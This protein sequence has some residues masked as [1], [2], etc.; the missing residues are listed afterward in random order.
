MTKDYL[1][2]LLFALGVA[3]SNCALANCESKDPSNLALEL[4]RSHYL[5]LSE[6]APASI[7]SRELSGLVSRELICRDQGQVCAIDW[8]FWTGAQDGQVVSGAKAKMLSTTSSTAKIELQYAFK[9][10]K[11]SKAQQLR[12]ELAFIRDVNGCW[13]VDDIIRKGVSLRQRL[14]ALPK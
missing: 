8:D 12:A 1:N 7:F 13:E 5:F 9:L 2:V 14:S 6:Q 11:T 4:F 3:L 10:D